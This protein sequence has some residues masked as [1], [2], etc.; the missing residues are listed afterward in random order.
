MWKRL[1]DVLGATVGLVLLSP[2]VLNSLFKA[3]TALSIAGWSKAKGG[4]LFS[5]RDA[6]KR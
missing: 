1:F 4:V 6:A 5:D 3:A 2:I